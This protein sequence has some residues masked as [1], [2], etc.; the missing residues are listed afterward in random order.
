VAIA[1]TDIVRDVTTPEDPNVV[2]FDMLDPAYGHDDLFSVQKPS[3]DY[4]VRRTL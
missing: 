4:A 3:I 1:G 2:V